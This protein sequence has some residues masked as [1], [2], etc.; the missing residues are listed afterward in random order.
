MGKL[1]NTRT[2]TVGWKVEWPPLWSPPAQHKT[3]CGITYLYK[4]LTREGDEEF[5]T[6]KYMAIGVQRYSR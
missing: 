1:N 2:G 6:D 5:T 4:A 3:S